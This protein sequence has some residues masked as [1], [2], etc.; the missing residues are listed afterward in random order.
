MGDA[1]D[2]RPGL[3]GYPAVPEEGLA[4]VLSS[5]TGRGSL[6]EALS[7]PADETDPRRWSESDVRTRANRVLFSLLEPALARWPSRA[8]YWLDL[9]PATKV[10]TEEVRTHPFSGVAW[11]QSR[12]AYG[13]PPSAFVGKSST[14]EVDTLAVQVLR[15]TIERLQQVWADAVSL[16]PDLHSS[17]ADP[18]AAALQL[19]AHEPLATVHPAAPARS[20]LVA[21]K[22]EGAP[23]GAVAEVAKLLHDAEASSDFLVHQLLMPDDDIRW[24]LFHLGTFGVLLA[25]LRA[26]G[27]QVVSK[28][29]ISASSGA[30]NY[31]VR[32]PAGEDYQLWFE[33]SGVWAELDMVSPFVEATSSV[34][35]ATR[36][37]GAD[38]LMLSPGRKALVVEC[39]YSWN[40]DFV[41]RNGYYQAVAYGAEARSRFATEVISAAVGP[42]GVVNGTSSASLHFGR[43]VTTSPSGLPAIVRELLQ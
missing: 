7:V 1:D 11:A 5:W 9:L 15:W 24:R 28:R 33:A 29:P 41:A 40:A 2:P 18:L 17:S 20:D 26:E 21:L 6:Y 31:V 35:R 37:N 8:S 32:T 42:D 23:W 12:R 25:T 19:L 22:R 38:I 4:A 36:T 27:C 13:W 16:A 30:P 14:R 43:V 34:R 3:S 10:R 39:K